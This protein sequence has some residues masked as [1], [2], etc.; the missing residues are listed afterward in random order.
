MFTLTDCE[1]S[2][3]QLILLHEINPQFTLPAYKLCSL[4]QLYPLHFPL[5]LEETCPKQDL[6]Q[7]HKQLHN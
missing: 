1:H 7:L 3:C 4:R 2:A 5:G 6:P